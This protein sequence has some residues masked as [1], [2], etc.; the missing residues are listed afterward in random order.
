MTLTLLVASGVALATG[1]GSRRR[2]KLGRWAGR[3]HPEGYQRCR[4]GRHHRGQG[5]SPRGRGD[6]QGR[7]QAAWRRRRDRSA[8]QSQSRLALLKA[9][10]PEGYL[11]CRRRKP[12]YPQG[13]RAREGRE[14]YWLHVPGLRGQREGLFAIDVF[15]ARNATIM[16]NRAIGNVAGWNHRWSGTS[17][18]LSRRIDV[19]GN[20]D[21]KADGIV[22]TDNSR[23]TTVVK[24]DV[25]NIPEDHFAIVVVENS[26]NT[27]VAGNDLIANFWACS[28]TTPPGPRS[29]PT[30]SRTA[31]YPA[32]LSSIRPAPRSSPTT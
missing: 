28:S 18:P 32:R 15:G 12:R 13:Q 5:S 21:T 24:N 8:H 25:R 17:T 23:N 4:S 19:I 2:A 11:R 6:P 14:R 1:I 20:P 26:I 16:G 9:F 30:T 31:P 3:V 27:T 22:V 7:D 29:S 10:G